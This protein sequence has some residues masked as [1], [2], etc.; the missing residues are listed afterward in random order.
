MTQLYPSV[1][2]PKTLTRQVWD[3]STA[4]RIPGVGR[5]LD[6]ICGLL[7]QMPL[8]RYAGIMPMPRPPLLAKPDPDMDLATFVSVQAE[9]W[10]LHGNAAHLVTARYAGG[11]FSGWPAAG[12]WFPASQWH[13]T[14]EGGRQ[15]WWLNGREVDPDNVVHVRNGA[16][17][18]T[19]WIGQGVIERYVNSLDRI[20]LQ[21]ERERKDTA[22]GQVPSVA[23][24][25]PQKD[26]D[27]ADLDAAA[28]KWAD[29]FEGPGR[30]PVI[31]PN[32]T[33]IEPL[34]W[35]PNDAQANEARKLG[36][37]DVANMF[38]LDGY[39]L[40]APAGSFTYRTPGPMFLALVRTTLGRIITPFE[41]TWSDAWLPRGSEVRFDREAVQADELGTLVTTL[42]KATGGKPVMT[43]NEARTRLRLAPVEGGDELQAAAPPPPPGLEPP[44][45]DEQDEQ[46][47]DDPAEE[48]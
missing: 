37:Q 36:L 27:E 48:A 14:V 39:W 6:V 1:F 16:N 2:D 41:Q 23:V 8:D 44:E 42:T 33:T 24:T 30:R 10:L 47:Q 25:I 4:R 19:P 21:E 32:G 46:N 28:K 22:G 43:V 40:G 9:D 13:T 5:A 17:P 18:I 11:P 3:A 12:K 7:S 15:L 31:L 38:N 29:K 20:A 26:P 35:S 34:G 45:N